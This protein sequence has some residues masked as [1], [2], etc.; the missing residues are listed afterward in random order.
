MNTNQPSFC[1]C[2]TRT[3]FSPLH[4]NMLLISIWDLIRMPPLPSTF[5][6]KFC[7]K[8]LGYSPR[9]LKL[10]LQFSPF[11]SGLASQLPLTIHSFLAMQ[12][13]SLWRRAQHLTPVFLPRECHGQWSLVG[14]DHRVTKSQTWLKR[15]STAQAFSRMNLKTLP[16]ST[17][18]PIS[19]PLPHF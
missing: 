16:A 7:S 9:K 1:H 18:Y 4:N 12:T 11:L 13:F 5:L 6:P 14:Y 3:L 2:I 10:S 19:K 8:L 15:L 17:F